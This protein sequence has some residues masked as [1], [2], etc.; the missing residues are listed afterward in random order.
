L[1]ISKQI[2]LIGLFTSTN[3]D[4]N[5]SSSSS[6]VINYA[7]NHLNTI[8][9]LTSELLIQHSEQDI[10]C[11]MAIGTKMVFDM[12]HRKPRPLAIF[13]GSCQT[14]ASAIA[15]TAGIYDM[16]IIIYS[17]TSSLFT[18]REKYPSLIR[19]VPGDSQHNIARKL[20]LKTYNWRR[21]GILYQYERQYTMPVTRFNDL[22]HEDSIEWEN[23]LSKG[24][25]F[26]DLD[27]THGN[28]TRNSLK[29]AF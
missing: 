26:N 17:E 20:L 27:E 22:L 21:F 5:S 8:D 18:A 14:V 9:N 11:D 29:D 2:P 1:T 15:E 7:V 16:T 28:R 25:S 6:L 13:S 3:H 23:A 4:N 10:P 12:I 24:I 19:T